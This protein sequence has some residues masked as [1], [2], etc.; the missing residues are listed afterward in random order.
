MGGYLQ[1]FGLMEWYNSLP[2]A[3]QQGI[4]N[5]AECPGDFGFKANWLFDRDISSTSQTAVKML[6]SFAL[7]AVKGK[8]HSTCDALILKARLICKTGAE[9]TYCDSIAKTIAEEKLIY[10]DQGKIDFYKPVIHQFI[11]EHP[12]ILQ[13]DINKHFDSQLE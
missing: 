8:D 13:S 5:A 6:C 11:K 9:G 1:Y 7:N 10:P 3:I 4:C 12:G 2:T